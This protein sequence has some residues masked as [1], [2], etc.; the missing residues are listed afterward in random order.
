MASPHVAGTAALIWAA[1]PN[2]GV[3]SVR[4]DL[5][6]TGDQLSSLSGVTVTG[7]RLDA[8]AALSGNRSAQPPAD[9]GGAT[10]VTPS[11]ATVSGTSDPCGTATS[12]QFEYGPTESYGAATPASSIGAGNAGVGVSAGLSGLAPGTTYHYRLVTI[13]GGTR[14]AGPDRTFTTAVAPPPQPPPVNPG[15]PNKALT[16]KDVTVTCTRIGSGRK[17][18]V[19]CTLRKAT[20]VSRLSAQLTKSRRLY[21]RASGK[22][23]RSGRVTLKLVRRLARGR[24]RVTMTLRD[25]KGAKRIK[26][27]TVKV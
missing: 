21:A 23:P 12:Y 3:A 10:G 4:C 13:R 11:G 1:R 18:T 8:A 20:A 7:R 25:A 5:L 15:S 14:L 2:A 27:L 24:Y 17:R 9:T 19:R 6:G 22:L 26:R 16:L